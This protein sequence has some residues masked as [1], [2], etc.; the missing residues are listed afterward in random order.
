[1]LPAGCKPGPQGL[2][3][4]QLDGGERPIKKI[5]LAPEGVITTMNIIAKHHL[6]TWAQRF[7]LEGLRDA[8]REI[9]R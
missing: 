8:I 3:S 1:M 4:R 6:S 2:Q 9:S 7:S 5:T